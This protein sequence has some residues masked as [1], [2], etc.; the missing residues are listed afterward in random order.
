MKTKAKVNAKVKAKIQ[1]CPKCKKKNTLE[2]IS[3]APQQINIFTIR[4]WVGVQCSN[5]GYTEK[6]Y[7]FK[8]VEEE[9]K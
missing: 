1:R 7:T 3:S 2:D 8:D 4:S 9:E 6:E 5:C